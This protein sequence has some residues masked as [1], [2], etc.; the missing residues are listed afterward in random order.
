MRNTVKKRTLAPVLIFLL[1]LLR[2]DQV[3]AGEDEKPLSA[4]LFR[5]IFYTLAKGQYE[6]ADIHK[7]I[8]VPDDRFYSEAKLDGENPFESRVLD[9]SSIAPFDLYSKGLNTSFQEIKDVD[10]AVTL[11]PVTIVI[12]P[13][14]FGEFI[15]H[16]PFHEVLVNKSSQFSKTWKDAI[17]KK[18]TTDTVFDLEQMKDLD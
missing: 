8:Y 18:P 10:G 12:I 17:A 16:F 9:Y 7:L 6:D 1:A 15:Q 11:N 14:I 3:N 5:N 4:A 2:P 13:G